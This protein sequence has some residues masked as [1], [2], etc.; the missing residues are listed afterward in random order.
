MST[1]L[2]PAISRA[3]IKIGLLMALTQVLLAIRSLV[4]TNCNQSRGQTEPQSV[5]RRPIL[6]RRTLVP[7]QTV[8]QS[9]AANVEV[10]HNYGHVEQPVV[11][12][13]HSS[14][15]VASLVVP[16]ARRQIQSVCVPDLTDQYSMED[17]TL[18]P[19]AGIEAQPYESTQVYRQPVQHQQAVPNAAYYS[20]TNPDLLGPAL[21][22]ATEQVKLTKFNGKSD[23]EEFI[24]DYLGIVHH[25]G[26]SDSQ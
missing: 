5:R 16:R 24:A 11:D 25:N 4:Q 8:A 10:G 19:C 1:S 14:D 26:W 3:V 21:G 2:G 7:T 13:A 17:Q 22:R 20:Q 15:R 9:R 6:S 12:P 23:V 18:M